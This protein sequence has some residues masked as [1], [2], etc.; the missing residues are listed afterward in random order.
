MLLFRLEGAKGSVL[1]ELIELTH[2]EE[3]SVQLA[4]V[5]SLVELLDFIDGGR[6]YTTRT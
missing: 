6:R 2:D 1:P 5:E 3:T 4:A